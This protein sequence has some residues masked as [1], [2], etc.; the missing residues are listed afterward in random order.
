MK[1]VWVLFRKEWRGFFASPMAYGVMSVF[2]ALMGIFFFFF[3]NQFQALNM[4]FGETGLDEITLNAIVVEPL[5]ANVC[6]LWLLMLPLITMR[7]LSEEYKMQTMV[8]LLTAPV[9]PIHILLGKFLAAFAFALVLLAISAI[10]PLIC[11][12]FGNAEWGPI[13]SANLGLALMGG[14]FIAIGL[15][16]SSLT[17]SQIFAAVLGFGLILF[18]WI[19]DFLGDVGDGLPVFSELSLLRHLEPFLTGVV[20][21]YHLGFYAVFLGFVLYLVHTRLS[22]ERWR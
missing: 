18:F 2:F 9:R 8:L 19:V 15:L 3:L 13:L 17:Q 5:Y 14:I 6:I 21:T 22:G 11:V 20:D 10:Y 4:Q 16:A 1:L 7:L 12:V